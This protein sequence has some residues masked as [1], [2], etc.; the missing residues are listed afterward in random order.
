ME[1]P[2]KA[3]FFRLSLE[4]TQKR[5]LICLLIH[6][7]IPKQKEIPCVLTS[8]GEAWAAYMSQVVPWSPWGPVATVAAYM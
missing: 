3:H 1:G 5:E 6:C 2:T 4:V 8:V 7:L